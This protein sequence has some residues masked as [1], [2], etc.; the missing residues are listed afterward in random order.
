MNPEIIDGFDGVKVYLLKKK[1]DKSDLISRILN[2][3]PTLIKL[4]KI[5]KEIKPDIIHTHSVSPYG[6]LGA[7]AKF[8]PFIIT[9]WG[10]DVLIDVKESK[11]EKIF[12]KLSLKKA[13][14]ITC[15]GENTEESLINLGVFPEKIKFITFG[16]D[17]K[18]FKSASDE[19]KKNLKKKYF[20]PDSNIIISTRTLNSIHNVD[21]FIKA[22]PFVIEKI[23]N[24][25]FLIAG[26]GTEEKKLINLARSLEIYN[27]IKFLGKL[28]EK[29]MISALL[30]SDIYVSTSLSESGLAA[31]TAEAMAC[32]L[33]VINTDTGD[34]K[35]W[36]EKEGGFI[37]PVENPV[38]LAKKIIY[39]LQNS[40]IRE[41]ARKVNRKVIE[42]RNNYY[43]EMGKMEEI[44]KKLVDSYAK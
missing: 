19:E 14:L 29:E 26:N 8:Y 1:I 13:D 23:S 37:I 43:K 9:P 32:G 6:Y 2:L 28:E 4:K 15:D 20:S 27:S 10:N 5:I 33:P 31:S 12:T 44:Y 30:A 39:L 11:I 22:I 42:E 18:K 40:E 36:L 16:V 25:K 3:A 21:T 38:V 17:I 35:L 34:I 41:K 24:A 7:L